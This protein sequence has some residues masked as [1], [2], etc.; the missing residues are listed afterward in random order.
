MTAASSRADA[1]VWNLEKLLNDK[2]PQFDPKQAAQ[3][4]SRIPAV[5]SYK[6]IDDYTL[7]V[8]TNGPDAFLP[9]QIGW[10][11]ISSPAQWEKVGK[12]WNKFA[13]TPSGT[14]PWKVAS[15]VPQTRAELVP[16]KEYWDPKRV[17]KLDKLVLLPLPE[18]TTR[19]AALRGGQVDWIEAPSPDAVP[20]LEKAGFKI[21]SNA[22]PHNWTWHLSMV[23]GSPWKDIRVRKAANLAVDRAGL[24]VMLGGLMIPA[25][26]F[27]VPGSQWFGH[28]SFD[29]K[30]DPEAAKKLL[31]EAGFSKSNPAKVRILI[32]AS[33]SGQMQPLGDERVY[34]A[35]PRRRR[36]QGRLRR[37]RM[38]HDDQP[39]ARRRE[40]RHGQGRQRNQLLLLHPGPVHRLRAPYRFQAGGA[41]RNQLGL[42][43][44]A[45][46]GRAARAGAH[47][48]HGRG[49]GQGAA[50]DARE[51]RRRG[52]LPV[53]DTRRRAA[54][55]VGQGDRAFVQR[56]T[57][58]RTSRRSPDEVGSL[59]PSPRLGGRGPQG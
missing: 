53:R 35:E 50:E 51:D 15:F 17:P 49:A 32:S 9:Y 26:G 47:H 25:K 52:A 29:V 48:L 37:G 19:T 1:V 39:V 11:M 44:G 13:Q 6:V 5:K 10:V 34:P 56:R 12:D 31:A 4:R 30:F 7:E 59:T 28:P 36:H 16:F 27:V 14:G 38:E 40:V 43:P 41:E 55:H 23:D 24:K 54:R 8:R 33:G 21:V 57:G 46:D 20:S 42:L 2:A 45:G 18:A 3:G 22:Y 58:S